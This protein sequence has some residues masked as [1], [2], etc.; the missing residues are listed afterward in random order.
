MSARSSRRR[1]NE[2]K[3]TLRAKIELHRSDANCAACHRKIDPLG[4]AFENYDAI[5]HWRT[6]EVVRDGSGDNPKLDPS[7]E[8]I[9]GRKFADADGLKKLMVDD[10]DKFNGAFIKKLATYAPSPRHDL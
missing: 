9:D 6:E 3:T 5:G 8:L 4:L 7:G 1:S 2:P 10:I